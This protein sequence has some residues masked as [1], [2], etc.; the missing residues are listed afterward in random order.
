V[1]VLAHPDG[2][3][4]GAKPERRSRESLDSYR[5][6]GLVFVL[7]PG[8]TFWMGAQDEDPKG[9]NYDPQAEADES[10]VHEVTL[11]PFF[12][13]KYEMTQG[14]WERF[15]GANP[16]GYGPNWRWKREPP[17]EGLIHQNQPWNPVEQV[18][19]VEC[20]DVLRRLGL[21][22]PTEAQWEYAA[23]AGNL[24]DGWVK[25]RGGPLGWVYQD[26]LEDRWVMH[27]PV[28]TFSPD[29]FGLHD[30]IGNVWEWCLDAYGG[31]DRDVE[32]GTGLS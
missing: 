23:R 6:T 1:G 4:A 20:P 30:V 32:P 2:R 5:D 22:L 8:G 10:P 21:T 12:M 9:R 19:W 15:T 11:A 28:G 27:A 31:Y 3:E 29:G 14:Q 16:S 25:S 13:S 18:T 7:I 24:A 17:G 26:C